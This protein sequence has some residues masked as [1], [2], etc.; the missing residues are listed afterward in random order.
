MNSFFCFSSLQYRTRICD[1]CHEKLLKESL[2]PNN[3]INN[4]VSNNY[5]TA[6]DIDLRFEIR[7][8]RLSAPTDT[9]SIS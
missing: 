2:M 8:E 9:Q 3:I 7:A 1:Y 5:E 6:D 4:D